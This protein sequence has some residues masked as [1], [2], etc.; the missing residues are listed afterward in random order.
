MRPRVCLQFSGGIDSTAALWLVAKAEPVLC[1]HTPRP[2]EPF[3]G[4]HYQAAEREACEAAVAYV[5]AL[6]DHYP[7]TLEI[8]ER[9]W[10]AEWEWDDILD[11]LSCEILDQRRTITV[12]MDGSNASEMEWR[13]YGE[14]QTHYHPDARIPSPIAGGLRSDIHRLANERP[15]LLGGWVDW[16]AKARRT[17]WCFD[18]PLVLLSKQEI[19]ALLPDDLLALT[20]ACNNPT[21]RDGRW[22][23]CGGCPKC[24]ERA[25]TKQVR[26]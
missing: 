15:D 11:N 1:I 25:L 4:P 23:P 18:V 19:A 24:E 9:D 8:I 20:V 7:V 26:A 21:P 16:I 10:P 2:A 6:A 22:A 17:D 12:M 3:L 13:P 5:N 14:M